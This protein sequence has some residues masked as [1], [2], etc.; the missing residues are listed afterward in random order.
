VFAEATAMHAIAVKADSQQATLEFD[1]RAINVVG[2]YVVIL[3][4]HTASNLEIANIETDLWL[5]NR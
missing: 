5:P 3:Q 1:K 2:K 4:N